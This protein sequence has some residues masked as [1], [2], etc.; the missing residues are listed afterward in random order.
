MNTD[1]NPGGKAV[2]S[3]AES[4]SDWWVVFAAW[5][6]LRICRFGPPCQHS[7]GGGFSQIFNHE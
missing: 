2:P 1:K 5:K 6:Y 3:E 4:A 7:G